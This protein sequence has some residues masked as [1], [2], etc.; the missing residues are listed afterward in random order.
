MLV[1]VSPDMSMYLLLRSQ[2]YEES[3]ALAEFIDNAIHAHQ[4]AVASNPKLHEK[5]TI[6]L[7]FYSNNYRDAASQNSISIIDD[8]VGISGEHLVHALKPAKPPTQRGLSEFGIGMK[9]AAVWFSP[10][11]SLSTSPTGE[12]FDYTV[13]FDLDKLIAAGK[14]EIDVKK[15]S[16]TKRHASGT[17]ILLKDLHKPI[18]S[19]RYVAICEALTEIYQT[20]TRGTGAYLTLNATYDGANQKNLKYQDS[21]ASDVLIARNYKVRG[22]KLILSGPEKSW[23]VPVEFDYLGHHVTGHLELRETGSY[24]NNPGLVLFRYGRVIK[25][26]KSKPYNPPKLYKTANKYGKQRI[27]GELHLDGL[28]VSYMKDGFNI[29]EDDFLVHILRL[30][31]VEA[32]MAQAENYRKEIPAGWVVEDEDKEGVS[33]T[34]P[35]PKPKA[36]EKDEGKPTQKPVSPATEE[37]NNKGNPKTNPPT[38]PVKPQVIPAPAIAL[39]DSLMVSTSNLAL[40]SIIEETIRQYRATRFIS[41]ALCLRIVLECGCLD[42]IRRD[43]NSEYRKVSDLGIQALLTHLNKN[44]SQLSKNNLQGDVFHFK[45]DHA[46]IKCIQANTNKASDQLDI[47]LLN[48]ISHGHFQPTKPTLDRV[49]LNIQPL[50]EWA[51]QRQPS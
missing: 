29:D 10:I 51:Y 3:Y 28:P 8:G 24:V 20:F 49:L 13:D 15:T 32:L 9:A 34:K 37:G 41:T 17:T 42:R 50:L 38:N 16:A 7:S 21:G 26:L 6:N 14:T 46:V 45:N 25:G 40:K 12:N 30:D 31:G 23:T 11:W 2:G 36:P 39:L 47:I 35:S 27:Y 4:N 18:A 1:D 48:T 44:A 19:D 33:P 43:F 5:L 22:K